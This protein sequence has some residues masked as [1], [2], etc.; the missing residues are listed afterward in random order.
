M[1]TLT[2]KKLE[3]KQKVDLSEY[4]RIRNSL[5]VNDMF[6]LYNT[7]NFFVSKNHLEKDDM[8]PYKKLRKTVIGMLTRKISI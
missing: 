7:L 1:S 4:I 2:T 8:K 3:S 6:L 5:S